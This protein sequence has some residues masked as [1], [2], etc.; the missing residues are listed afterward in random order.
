MDALQALWRWAHTPLLTVA[1]VSISVAK[2][3]QAIVAFAVVAWVAN[4]GARMARR[5]FQGREDISDYA[6]ALLARWVKVALWVIGVVIVADLIGFRLTSFNIFAGA[7]GVGIGFGLQ[8]VVNNFVCGLLLMVERTM[9]VGDVISVS[10]EMGRVLHIGAR[11][12]LLETP[13]GAVIAIPN[14]QFIGSPV[15]NWTAIGKR[16]R[17]H[18]TVSTATVDDP[19]QVEAAL[20]QAA[21][22]HP[23]VLNDP[24]PQ[25]WLTKVGDTLAF[26]LLV[27]T[28]DPLDGARQVQSDLN[29]AIHHAL[30]QRGIALKG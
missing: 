28:D 22:E 30:T 7:I 11:A 6:A 29:Y 5:Y 16:T 17:V 3:V 27:W 9:R 12:T 4:A 1:G 21:R 15:I 25:V 8:T 20:L 19:K 18:L 2:L 13:R 10:G 26:E 14:T 23:Q 24:S